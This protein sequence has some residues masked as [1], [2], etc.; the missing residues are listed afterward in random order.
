[1]SFAFKRPR[2]H[3]RGAL[4]RNTLWMFLGHVLR[5]GAQ[6]AY[7]VV[8]ARALGPEGY[9]AFAGTAALVSVF[10]PYSSMGS[11]NLLIRN[12]ARDEQAF[13]RAW[14]NALAM[15][16]ATGS[17]LVL[18]VIWLA[19]HILP[20]SVP[21]FLVL[22]VAVGDLVCLRL[23]DVAGQ[24]FQ[25]FRRLGWTAQ[26]QVIPTLLRLVAA[27]ALLYVAESSSLTWWGVFYGLTGGVSAGVGVW[28]VCRKLGKPEPDFGS[29][30]ASL[31]EG[32]YFA[33]SL[34]SQG[35]YNDIDK[36]LLARL[37][38]TEVAGVY[39][40][41]YRIVDAAFAPVRALLY[42]SYP[43]F[44]QHGSAGLRGS[45]RLAGRL[46]PA[47][48]AYGLVAC[49]GVFLGA[50]FIPVLLGP[51]FGTSADA[52]RLLAPLPF[53]RSLHYF[54]AD[55]LT[56]ADRQALRSFL[57][58]AVAVFNALLTFALVQG[59][60]WQ[61]AAYASLASDGLL[62]L[63]LWGAVLVGVRREPQ[64]QKQLGRLPG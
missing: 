45:L 37:I 10:A 54:A 3:L 25:A 28:L 4:L 61:G 59:F 62:A 13:A 12:V 47:A 64:L 18:L 31:K 42:A 21:A 34:S 23:A 11:G 32:F 36:T 5:T 16:V 24:A 46:T 56:G 41:A 8:L 44:F 29:A 53:L 33:V 48:A 30:T 20:P 50:R 2:G 39:A 7:F 27:L 1:M 17:G 43:L 35:V 9:G 15:T 52:A 51:G 63:L 55:T 58:I 60:S 38:S 40:A 26:L 57:Q 14:G 6:A 19:K 49:G 22:G